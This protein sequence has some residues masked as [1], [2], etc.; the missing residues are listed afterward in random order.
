M[1]EIIYQTNDMD[2]QYCIFLKLKITKVHSVMCVHCPCYIWFHAEMQ[3]KEKLTPYWRPTYGQLH[4]HG[5]PMEAVGW[6]I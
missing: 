3:A 1:T 4:L 2:Q 6:K 5:N